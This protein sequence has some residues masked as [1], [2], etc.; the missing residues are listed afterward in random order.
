[1]KKLGLATIAIFV[2]VGLLSVGVGA[3][4]SLAVHNTIDNS[5][6]TD[7]KAFSSLPEQGNCN[8]AAWN[9][10]LTT[11]AQV[12]QWL[13][14]QMSGTK[15]SWFVRK[16]GDYYTN[17]IS[18]SVKSNGNVAISFAGFANLA[19]QN[20]PESPD[21]NGLEG[22]NQSIA[23]WYGVSEDELGPQGE[24]FQGW[25]SAA[26]LNEESALLPDSARLHN[27]WTFKLWNRIDVVNCNSAGTYRN[28]G[29]ITLTVLNQL[30]WID[31]AGNY[32]AGLDE[33]VTTTR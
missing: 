12:A 25:Y 26:Q 19:Y 27:G 15:W 1:M 6:A 29:V 10:Q 3:Q 9:I 18:A 4:Q 7:A 21:Y 14:W 30:D 31:E 28:T 33:F 5:L 22:V 17:C 23:T 16:P 24:T 2:I 20:N 32:K 8:K 13:D 11:E